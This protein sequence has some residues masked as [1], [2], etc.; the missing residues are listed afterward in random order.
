[1]KVYIQYGQTAM[2]S[3]VFTNHR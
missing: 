3:S 2:K 1:M